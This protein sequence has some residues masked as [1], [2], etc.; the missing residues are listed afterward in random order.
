VLLLYSGLSR[1]K[2][3]K[4]NANIPARNGGRKRRKASGLATMR[5]VRPGRE[6]SPKVKELMEQMR[7]GVA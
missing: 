7:Q 5:F 3:L 6:L 1:G 4:G 2:T